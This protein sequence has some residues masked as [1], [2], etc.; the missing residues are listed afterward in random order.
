MMSMKDKVV[1]ILQRENYTFAQLADYLHMTPDGLTHELNNK[2]LE[3]RNLEAISKILKVPLYSFFRIPGQQAFDH[4]QKPYYVNQL[5][6]GEDDSKTRNQLIEEIN[7]LK[8]IIA[9]KEN[10]LAKL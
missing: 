8:Q 5:W 3:I 6:T 4:Q 9:L 2:T 1:E 7:L 10:Q